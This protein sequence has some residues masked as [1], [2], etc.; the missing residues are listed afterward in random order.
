MLQRRTLPA[1][2][3]LLAC[4]TACAQ[5]A[6][7][8]PAAGTAAAATS[9]PEAVPAS[10]NASGGD[11]KRENSASVF[12]VHLVSDF[13][14][15]K[16]F[17]EDGA[18][19]RAKAGVKGHLLSRL[20]DGRVV[21]HLFASDLATVQAA[22][23]SP[24]L[25]EYLARSGAPDASLVW[26]AH[27]TIVK[28]PPAPPPGETFSLFVKLRV[29]DLPA[30]ERAFEERAGV[31]AE[32]GVIAR[33]LHQSVLKDDLV[34]LHFVGM[35]RNELEAL[36]ARPEFAQMLRLAGSKETP[37]TFVGVDASRSR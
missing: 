29:S 19:E 36:P 24:R 16:K 33:G 25:Q 23:D 12:V 21:I 31:F 32:Q 7:E 22:L 30:L 26:V 1:S 4:V 11:Q 37:K 34:F 6:T 27:D 2:L 35:S 3:V 20:D 9:A 13:E 28:L 14:A 10:A 17:F 8:P 18:A 5:Q 15:F